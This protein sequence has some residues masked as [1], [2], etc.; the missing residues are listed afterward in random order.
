MK[1]IKYKKE[2]NYSYSLGVYA[3][4][5]L[6]K[7]RKD[8]VD[9]VV[10]SREGDKNSGVSEIVSIC[11]LENIPYEFDD[12]W[13]S[14]VST[15]ENIYAVGIF[16][17]FSGDLKEQENNL[18]LV[19]PSDMGNLGTIIRTMVGFGVSNLA[20]IKPAV[21]IFDP[22][23][24]R[25]SQGAIFQINFQYFDSAQ[26]FFEK[27]KIANY[28][29]MTDEEKTLKSIVFQK[30]CSLIFGNESSGLSEALKTYGESIRISQ[31]DKI[32]SLN[33]AVSVGIVL[34]QLMVKS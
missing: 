13:V 25:A 10:L 6:L 34:H 30:P 32:D 9:K 19:N 17:K 12:L 4:L 15:K 1:F 11:T 22:K 7:N 33:L 24:V 29:F 14:K 16:K 27:F 3:T 21:D 23:V 8:L 18:V 26:C 2:L 31:T 20:L 28:L 5:E